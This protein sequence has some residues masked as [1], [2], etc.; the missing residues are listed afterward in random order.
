MHLLLLQVSGRHS[1]AG[2]VLCDLVS[3]VNGPEPLQTLLLQFLGLVLA[4]HRLFEVQLLRL[5]LR[6]EFVKPLIAAIIRLIMLITLFVRYRV[7]I[8]VPISTNQ[9]VEVTVHV[10]V[11]ALAESGSV[12]FLVSVLWITLARLVVGVVGTLLAELT[13]LLLVLKAL[14]SLFVRIKVSFISLKLFLIVY[15]LFLLSISF[16]DFLPCCTCCFYTR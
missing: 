9:L 10:I 4:Y 13:H 3:G 5:L 8:L 15:F 6:S 1:V 11:A 14:T 7:V 12:I 16:S 2:V